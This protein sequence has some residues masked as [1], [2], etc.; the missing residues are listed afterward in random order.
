MGFPTNDTTVQRPD[1][2]M[3]VTEYIENAP[4]AGYIGLQVM[5]LF[6]VTEQSATFPVLP[7]EALLSVPDTRRAMR[8]NYNRGDWEFEEGYYATRENGW[9]EPLDDR[10]RKLYQSKFD[11][12]MVATRRATSIILRN[13]EVRIASKVFNGSNFTAHPVTNEWDDAAN[14]TP[15]DDINAGKLAVR[16]ACGMIPNTLII[17]FTTFV[18]LKRCA[19]VVELLKY[20]FPGEKINSMSPAQLAVVLDV[21]KVLVGG[22]VFNAA[23]KGQNASIA[24]VWDSEYAMLTI[25]SDAPDISEPCIGRTFIWTEDSENNAVVEQYRDDAIRSDI[26]RCR[27]DTDEAFIVSLDGN[28]NIVSNISQAVSYLLSNI[29]T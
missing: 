29:T 11:A 25:T 20:T 9:E 28:K 24:D 7:K 10:E 23:K 26:F 1:L 4:F 5:P 15:I 8:S 22:A 18:N 2:G 3:A 19:Q 17:S 6:P 27:H 12:E 21:E 13:Q 16:Q 14:A